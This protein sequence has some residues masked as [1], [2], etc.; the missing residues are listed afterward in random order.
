[1]SFSPRTYVPA[2]LVVTSSLVALATLGCQAK[3]EKADCEK[4]AEHDYGILDQRNHMSATPAGQKILANLK[5]KSIEGCTG[6]YTKSQVDCHL[7][8]STPKEMD[9]CNPE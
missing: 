6:K 8:A 3:A 9:A 4:M 5:Q 7:K 2:A 1:M